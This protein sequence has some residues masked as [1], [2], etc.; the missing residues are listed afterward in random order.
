MRVIHYLKVNFVSFTG[1]LLDVGAISRLSQGSK[2]EG[3]LRLSLDMQYLQIYK[4]C[5]QI[6]K[7]ILEKRKHGSRREIYTVLDC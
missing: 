1:R 4:K 7:K 2:E 3:S 5:S 6:Y